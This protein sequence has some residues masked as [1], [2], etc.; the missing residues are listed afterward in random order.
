MV[1]SVM[2]AGHAPDVAMVEL[3]D[4]AAA[5]LIVSFERTFAI[6]VE[7]V[8]DAA[9]PLSVTGLIAAAQEINEMALIP[10]SFASVGELAAVNVMRSAPLVGIPAGR[11]M[12]RLT[13]VE[14]V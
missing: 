3:A 14:V 12:E 13:L 8:P 1:F 9:V 6:A 5:P 11:V 7:A 4:V 2:P 10:M